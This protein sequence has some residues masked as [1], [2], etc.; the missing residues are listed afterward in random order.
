MDKDTMIKNMK[1]YALHS[2]NI[3]NSVI[4]T[5]TGNPSTKFIILSLYLN[6]NISSIIQNEKSATLISSF[7]IKF[8]QLF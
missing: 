6:I 3:N 2:R 8:Y 5:Y 1:I 4:E 7:C